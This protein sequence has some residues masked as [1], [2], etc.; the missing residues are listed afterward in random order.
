MRFS[1]FVKR[2]GAF[3]LLIVVAAAAFI[4]GVGKELFWDWDECLYAQYG[5]EMS[6]TGHF[7]SNI[8]NGYLDL[9]KPPLYSWLLIPLTQLQ[10]P[11]FWLRFPNVVASLALLIAVYM[12]CTRYFSRVVGYIAVLILLC[13]EAF[14]IYSLHL[15]TDL[16]FTLFLFL[17]IWAWIEAKHFSKIKYQ[18]SY[19]LPYVA[20]LFIGLAT[21][22][23]G[24]SSLSFLIAMGVATVLFPAKN[25]IKQYLQ[26]LLAWALTIVPWHM[27]ALLN[28][29]GHFVKV[30]IFDNIIKRSRYPIEF[31][32]ERIWFYAAL[33]LKELFPWILLAVAAPLELVAAIFKYLKQKKRSWKTFHSGTLSKYQIIITIA[34]LILIPLA[35]IT[36]VQTRIAWYIIP[37]YPFIAIYLAYG[38]VLTIQCL[39]TKTLLSK[40][41][42]VQQVLIGALCLGLL[43]DA[44]SLIVRETHLLQTTTD[45]SMR[46]QAALA[47]QKTSYPT[48]TYLVPFGERQAR[49]Y[50]PPTEQID[51]TWVYGGNP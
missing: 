40:L 10:K 26:L 3:V 8:W 38:A 12:F 30:Y 7:I 2:H 25:S 31:H 34:L 23:K 22:F 1:T 33:M 51:M 37:V 15:D 9:Q 16:L 27:L 13:A 41:P 39:S 21:M 45:I 32:R 14:V 20:G 35:S 36:R 49:V 17:G 11:E 29:D 18:N 50:L 48:L 4:Q 6:K 46:N 5:R 19:L 43:F 42:R 24:L 47:V 44:G 28:Y